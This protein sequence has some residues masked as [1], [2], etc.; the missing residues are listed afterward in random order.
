MTVPRLLLLSL[1]FVLASDSALPP[2]A[3]AAEDLPGVRVTATL[4]KDRVTIGDVFGYE[5]R[6]TAPKGAR[7]DTPDL[8]EKL[9]PLEIRDL[10][11]TDET[12]KD[13]LNV[14]LAYR[15]QVFEVGKRII[16]GLEIPCSLP[17]KAKA[18]QARVPG[19]TLQVAGVVPP[20]AKD[21]QDIRDPVPI[22]MRR[23]DWLLAALIAALLVAALVVLGL[24]MAR[25]LRNRRRRPE[26]PKVVTAQSWALSRLAELERRNLPA[27]DDCPGHYAE[28][29]EILREFV[30]ARYDLPANEGTTASLLRD[31]WRAGADPGFVQPLMAVLREADRVRFGRIPVGPADASTALATAREAIWIAGASDPKPEEEDA[32]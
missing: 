24:W 28:L 13:K 21:V 8:A 5:I 9:A 17:G 1:L 23:S 3:F 7:I 2:R 19:V 6:I 22:R 15:L 18:A 29:V 16:S 12:S 26:P 10:K 11:R 27:L 31:L 14:T 25:R 20:D 30:E 4:D 32:G